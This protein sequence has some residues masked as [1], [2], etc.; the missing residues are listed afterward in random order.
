VQPLLVHSVETSNVFH[1]LDKKRPFA[2][3]VQRYVSP[4][5]LSNQPNKDGI[6]E[7]EEE[8]EQLRTELKDAEAVRSH[9]QIPPFFPT[10]PLLTDVLPTHYVF[11]LYQRYR[12]PKERYADALPDGLDDPEA[13]A[14][15]SKPEG[16]PGG[17]MEEFTLRKRPMPQRKFHSKE[18]AVTE[19]E[20]LPRR[21]AFRGKRG[22]KLQRPGTYPTGTTLTERVKE[23]NEG[24]LRALR[25]RVLRK[26]Q[27]AQLRYPPVVGGFA[28]SGDALHLSEFEA[29]LATSPEERKQIKEQAIAEGRPVPPSVEEPEPLLLPLWQPQA[30]HVFIA[31]HNKKVLK[32]RLERTQNK[33]HYYQKL[34]FLRLQ[35][36]PEP[37][38]I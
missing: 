33:A 8:G 10:G 29:S 18:R 14:Q 9:P 3:L 32:R 5:L 7:K 38:I 21:K 25:R 1:V 37:F 24:R 27:R 36:D 22:E 11:S 19:D 35:E 34:K 30:R 16:V 12:Y 20:L 23:A 28:W 15:W 26:T 17:K 2:N 4:Y 6:K 31:E 13:E